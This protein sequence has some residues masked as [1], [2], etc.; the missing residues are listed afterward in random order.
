[1]RLSLVVFIFCAPLVIA[2]TQ[3]VF[4]PENPTADEVF[5]LNGD[6]FPYTIEIMLPLA[7]PGAKH[8]WHVEYGHGVA[9][10]V[11]HP[12]NEFAFDP[13]LEQ[14]NITPPEGW[15]LVAVNEDATLALIVPEP[16][17]VTYDLLFENG[18]L[19][20]GE[21]IRV[22]P[23]QN[24]LNDA[25]QK[26]EKGIVLYKATLG[27]LIC[28]SDSLGR[29]IAKRHTVSA[30]ENIRFCSTKSG[31]SRF[32][33]GLK[34][35]SS[36]TQFQVTVDISGLPYKGDF[37]ND[38]ISGS[39]WV[40]NTSGKSWVWGQNANNRVTRLCVTIQKNGNTI[41]RSI[42]IPNSN[43]SF[44][45]RLNGC[46]NQLIEPKTI[47]Y[48]GLSPYRPGPN[49][50]ISGSVVTGSD[51]KYSIELPFRWIGTIETTN[52]EACPPPA[53]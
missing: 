41:Y 1:M 4:V 32:N 20:E 44:N 50:P 36:E 16:A 2:G 25:I 17:D 53:P 15:E 26:N 5:V 13:D 31:T 7:L 49:P 6:G 33:V 27:H 8:L 14:Y 21:T 34:E 40:F 12:S 37:T 24:N 10:G 46:E 23:V 38:P 39:K 11:P 51:G 35:A 28:G 29:V 47:S 9:R 3:S 52:V 42:L 22:L 48:E 19:K 45:V 43:P 30:N 18:C